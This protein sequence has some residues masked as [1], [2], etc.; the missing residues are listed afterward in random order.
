MFNTLS[1]TRLT[2]D[3]C[4]ATGSLYN[5]MCRHCAGYGYT[6]AEYTL[7]TPCHRDCEISGVG[8]DCR[9]EREGSDE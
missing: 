2:C 7:R 9:E 8:C 5:A 3:P 6:I 4:E 1:P